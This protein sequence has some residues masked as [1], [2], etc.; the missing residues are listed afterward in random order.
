M[1][2][3]IQDLIAT[4]NRLCEKWEEEIQQEKRDNENLRMC[5]EHIMFDIYKGL[6]NLKEIKRGF[7]DSIL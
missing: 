7:Y 5:F 3:D 1:E 2:S 4:T 6:N